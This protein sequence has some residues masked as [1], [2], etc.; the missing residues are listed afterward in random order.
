MRILL[1]KTSS[2]GDII[3][4]F[5]AITDAVSHFPNLTIDWVVEESFAPIPLL[6]P[7]V[8]KVIPVAL[9][10]WRRQLGQLTTYRQIRH[11]LQTL[12][13]EKYDLVIDAQGLLK[14]SFLSLFSRGHR[15][16]YGW[17]G[18]REPL[19]SF[20]YHSTFNIPWSLTSIERNRHLF[21]STFG[22][23]VPSIPTQAGLIFDAHGESRKILFLPGASWKT[24]KW[25]IEYWQELAR[26]LLPY[27]VT[28]SVPWSTP[29]EYQEALTI[30]AAGSHVH[31]LQKMDLGDL[32]KVVATHRATIAVD[33]G[34]GYLSAAFHI[35]T[36]IVWGPTSP[37]MIGQFDT[38]QHNLRSTVECAPCLKRTCKNPHLS[39]VQPP[40]LAQLTP[41]I[42][43]THLL[44]TLPFLSKG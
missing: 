32:A 23:P 30:Q 1:I 7:A 37:K 41:D 13:Q 34:L 35:P 6:H 42:L 20:F 28:I 33:S 4:T 38:F 8:K 11:T 15:Y 17:V 27:G 25:P 31:V 22:Y 21:A 9:R 44:Q 14:S 24:K 40:C 2:L 29:E 26:L 18:A 16:G 43:L 36:F 3:H 10:R 12:R 19:A 39:T 5:P